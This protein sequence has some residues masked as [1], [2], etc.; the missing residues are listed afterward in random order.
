MFQLTIQPPLQ[1]VQSEEIARIQFTKSP[2]ATPE[3]LRRMEALVCQCA[4]A[5]LVLVDVAGV[6][7]WCGALLG[8]FQR[9]QRRLAARGCRVVFCGV[10]AGR[11]SLMT[12]FRRR[13]LELHKGGSLAAPSGTE[14][15]HLRASNV[16]PPLHPTPCPI[17]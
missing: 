5:P 13:E 11:R 12:A 16:R 17:A 2:Q 15:S 4:R 8:M 7:H 3:S 9:I 14:H 10:P 1:I 6:T